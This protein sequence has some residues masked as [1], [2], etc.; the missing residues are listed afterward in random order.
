[1]DRLR[2]RSILESVGHET[3]CT[4]DPDQVLNYVMGGVEVVVT[5]LQMT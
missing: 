5:D 3:Y 4:E 1:M 2:L